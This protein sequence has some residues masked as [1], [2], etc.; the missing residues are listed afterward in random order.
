MQYDPERDMI[1][2]IFER[3]EVKY[4]ITAEQRR[5]MLKAM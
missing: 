4:I 5:E 3:K 1:Q 2:S